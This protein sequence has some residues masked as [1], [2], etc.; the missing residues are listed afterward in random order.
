MTFQGAPDGAGRNFLDVY[1]A[2]M[3]DAEKTHGERLLDA[4]DIH[5]YP[6]AQGDGVRITETS[7]K[8]G[9]AAARIQAPRSLWDANYVE[10]SWIS[11][12]IGHKAIA[13]L[14]MI[15]G[16]I[17]K[18]YPHTKL[19]ISEYNYGGG[20]EISGAISQ[21]DVLGIFGRYGLFASCNWGISAKDTAELDG[22]RAFR[23]FDGN[24]AKFGDSELVVNGEIPVTNSVYAALDSSHPG[25]LTLVVIN[26][27]A[28]AQ[29]FQIAF[30]KYSPVSAQAYTVTASNLGHATKSPVTVSNENV[31]FASP[32]LSVSTIEVKS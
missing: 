12:S 14:P 31:I 3:H 28:E 22:F 6:E 16:K 9:V 17:D 10:K 19:S 13:L 23:D 20:K 11:D 1:L 7:P 18:F 25:R 24:G 5:W 26:K 30:R 15:E 8:P 21:A 27:S 4:L 2:A 32:G 29:N